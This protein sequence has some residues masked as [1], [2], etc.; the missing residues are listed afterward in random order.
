M[1]VI[2]NLS[3]SSLPCR[4]ARFGARHRARSRTPVIAGV[5]LRGTT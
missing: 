5:V 4:G 2:G 1:T 3:G